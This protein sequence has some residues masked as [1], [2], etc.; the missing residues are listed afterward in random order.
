[1]QAYGNFYEFFREGVQVLGLGVLWVYGGF[2][3]IFVRFSFLFPMA[4]AQNQSALKPSPAWGAQKAANCS[5]N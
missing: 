1:M 3:A 4:A 5:W 2:W